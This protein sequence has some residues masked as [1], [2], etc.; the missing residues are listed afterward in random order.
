MGSWGAIFGSLG[1]PWEAKGAAE[2]TPSGPKFDFSMIWGAFRDLILKT[3]PALLSVRQT[4]RKLKVDFER[5]N[6]GVCTRSFS[7]KRVAWRLGGK[8]TADMA[9]FSG[10]RRLMGA[11]ACHP[12][13]LTKTGPTQLPCQLWTTKSN[14]L[15]PH[16]ST[17]SCSRY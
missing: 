2:R 15:L 9:Y 3:F 4:R 8:F 17:S 1:V 13:C 11:H 16:L 6:D 12:A 10:T 7:G 14:V 5:L